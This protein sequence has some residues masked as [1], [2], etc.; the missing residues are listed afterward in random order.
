MVTKQEVEESIKDKDDFIKID[1]LNR[2]LRQADN[3]DLKKFLLLNLAAVNEKKN[4]LNDAIKNVVGAADI[5]LTYREKRELF[6]KEVELWVKL[7]DFMMA[8]KALHRAFGYANEQEKMDVLD[9]VS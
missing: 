5:A 7:G 6:M 2:Y 8:E 3:L 1:Y 9:L 4:L